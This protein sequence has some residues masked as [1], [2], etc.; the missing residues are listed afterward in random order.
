MAIRAPRYHMTVGKFR[1]V[2]MGLILKGVIMTKTRT[3]LFGTLAMLV[4]GIAYAATEP[5]PQGTS[6]T[7]S[8]SGQS[9]ATGPRLSAQTTARQ[10]RP[11]FTI[12]NVA[13]GIWTPLPPPYDASAN[14]NLAANPLP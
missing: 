4:A 3:L 13:V 8:F 1:I 14:R 9:A 7:L 11:L 12:G 2:A 6:G 10:M 5:A